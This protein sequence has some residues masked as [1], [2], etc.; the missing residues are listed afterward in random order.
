M[1]TQSSRRTP[2][3]WIIGGL[4]VVLAALVW[5]VIPRQPA[6]L[7]QEDIPT[8]LDEAAPVDPV[9]AAVEKVRGANP[10]DG[11]LELKALAEAEPPNVDAVIELG[12][13][14]IQS[15]QLDKAKERF[16]QAIDLAPERAEPLVQLGMLE[17]D[18]GNPAEA[19]IHFERAVMVDST[20]HN[21]W[22][23][24]AQ[25]H[26]RLGNPGLALAGYQK[27]LPLSPDTIIEQAVRQ[28]IDLL[29]QPNP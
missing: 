22:F 24:Q 6:G 18:G 16:V 7:V 13:F 4:C 8:S 26:E 17:L 3:P 1:S 23:F 12:R 21:A 10:M 11:I 28:R 14:S 19:L 15:G 29:S 5:Q 2:L 25:C 20:A 9:L 27:F